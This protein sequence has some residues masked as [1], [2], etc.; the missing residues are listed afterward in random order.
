MKILIT[1]CAG[2]IGFNI[3]NS[4][5][6]SWKIIGIDNMN[7]YYDIKLKKNRLKVLLKKN[8][9]KFKKCDISNYLDLRKVFKNNNIDF[10]INLAAQAGVRY[11][12]QHPEA[13]TKSNL[14]GF[15]NIL[16]LCKDFEIKHLITASTSSVYG[17]AVNKKLNEKLNTDKPIQYYA[18]TKKSNEVM[19]YSYSHLYKIPITVLRFFTVYGPWGRPDMALFKFVKNILDDKPIEVYNYGNHTRGFTYVDTISLIIK[20]LIK[21]KFNKKDKLYEIFNV[22][23]DHKINLKKFIKIIEGQLNKKAKIKYKNLQPGDVINTQ[24][25]LSK[26]SKL[27]KNYQQ[28]NLQEGISNFI[29]WF[30]NYYK[31]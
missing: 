16:E 8:N 18:A 28:V 10:V 20:K 21:K 7:K 1:G 30:K 29:S 14:I 22:G 11:S 23:G 24:A 9:F 4:F 3:C 25:D 27:L 5:P 17:L 19:A 6:R 26:S 2:F 15:A 31:Y 13:Y 12:I